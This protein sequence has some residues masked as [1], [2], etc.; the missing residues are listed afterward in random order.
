[1]KRSVIAWLTQPE[2][3]D[4]NIASETSDKIREATDR[5][6]SVDNNR[7]PMHS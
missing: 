7:H 1:M 5:S 6:R 2:L 3:R 4:Q